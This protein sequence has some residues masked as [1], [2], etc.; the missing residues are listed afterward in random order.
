MSGALS[1]A[2]CLLQVYGKLAWTNRAA[3]VQYRQPPSDYVTTLGRLSNIAGVYTMGV[4]SVAT[5]SRL[6]LITPVAMHATLQFLLRLQLWCYIDLSATTYLIAMES[7]QP[8]LRLKSLVVFI[9]YVWFRKIQ[10]A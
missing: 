4:Y 7:S 2:A 3:A 10:V 6:T 1:T 8:A 5:A 9:C